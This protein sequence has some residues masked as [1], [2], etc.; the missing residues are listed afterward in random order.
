MN[1]D[2]F[3]QKVS[4]LGMRVFF[5]LLCNARGRSRGMITDGCIKTDESSLA[6]HEGRT[7]AENPV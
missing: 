3:C 6:N 7:I 5:I 2:T 1:F 4:P